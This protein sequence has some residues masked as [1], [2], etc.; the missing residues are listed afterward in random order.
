[1][2]PRML[3]VSTSNL[4]RL[5]IPACLGRLAP[6]SC[7]APTLQCTSSYPARESGPREGARTFAECARARVARMWARRLR[8]H[9]LQDADHVARGGHR[10]DFAPEPGGGGAEGRLAEQR[11]HTLPHRF[12]GDLVGPE[13]LADACRPATF[14]VP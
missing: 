2:T 6:K 14:G 3:V 8:D 5:V 10:F 1:M 12:G 13:G 9:V 11:A 4:D 7:V